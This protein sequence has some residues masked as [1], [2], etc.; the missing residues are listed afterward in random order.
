MTLVEEGRLLLTDPVA[1]YIPAFANTTVRG[2]RGRR[3]GQ[4]RRGAPAASRFAT[5]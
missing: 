2:N 4:S 1:K 5:C 3:V